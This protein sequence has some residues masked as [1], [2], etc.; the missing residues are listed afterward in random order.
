M[1]ASAPL[2]LRMAHARW[3]ARRRAEQKA[4]TWQ[5]FMPAGPVRAHVRRIQ[6]A[7]MPIRPLAV[8]L[9]LG[10]DGLDYLMYGDDR[11]ELGD[12]VR[13]ETGEAVLAFWPK[14]SDFPDAARIDPTGTHRRVEALETL[15]FGRLFIGQRVGM[16]KA[17]FSRALR[18]DR[19]TAQ[20]ARSVMRAYDEL[21]DQRPEDHGV[22]AWVA[23]RT[24][25]A[26][27]A[28]GSAGPLSWDDDT[29]DDPRAVAITDAPAP[30]P[31]G[32]E[33]AVVRF[34][35]GE[36][37]VLDAAGRR[38]AI[39]HLMEWTSKTPEEI[40]AELEMSADAVSRAWERIKDKARKEGHR[41]PQRRVYVQQPRLRRDEMESAA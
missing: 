11:H 29:I 30:V 33:Q 27:A 14:I 3:Q 13:R 25:R 35:M 1:K 28:A 20:V 16:P 34:L 8:R 24:R 19:I 17:S 15:G 21:W 5:P 6:E 41:A 10:R 12:R 18:A 2:H 32:G 39:A 37:V 31:V 4:G 23:D 7:G 9:G 36:S 40:G 38:D 22:L 26:A